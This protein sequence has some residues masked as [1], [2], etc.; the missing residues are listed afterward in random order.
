MTRAIALVSMLLALPALLLL[1]VGGITANRNALANDVARARR[2]KAPKAARRNIQRAEQ[3]MR[4]HDE[5]AFNEALWNTLTDYFGHRLNLAPGEVS[6]QTVLRHMPQ[7]AE[8]IEALYNTIEQ[9]RYGLGAV[10]SSKAEMKGLL[11]QTT[12]T[13]KQCERIKL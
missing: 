9:R 5:T 11:R 4:K 10:S 12:A 7:Q 1:A 3:A 6:L 2:Q 13:L 8:A